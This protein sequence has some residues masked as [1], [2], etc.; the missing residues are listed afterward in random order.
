MHTKHAAPRA[1]RPKLV[2]IIPNLR[3]PNRDRYAL[4]NRKRLGG[5]HA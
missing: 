1:N 3:H 5:H 4:H 2:I